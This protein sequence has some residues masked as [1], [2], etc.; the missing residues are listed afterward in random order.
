MRYLFLISAFF[1]ASLLAACDQGEEVSQPPAED[2]EDTING[3]TTE[4]ET[5]IDEAPVDRS[6]MDEAPMDEPPA[7]EEPLIE[8]E[9]IEEEEEPAS[10]ESEEEQPQ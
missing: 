1:F 2:S 3:L 9:V 5:P 6:P 7:D 10:T 4:P 8:E